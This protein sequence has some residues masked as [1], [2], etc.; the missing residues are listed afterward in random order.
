M[1]KKKNNKIERKKNYHLLL[2][3]LKKKLKDAFK[4]LFLLSEQIKEFLVY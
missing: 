2:I 4:P 3:E 1:K